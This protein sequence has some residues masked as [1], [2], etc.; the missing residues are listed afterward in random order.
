M[1]QDDK[2]VVASTDWLDELLDALSDGLVLQE[3]G[4]F[5]G[6]DAGLLIREA[7]VLQRE[8]SALASAKT[9]F[10]SYRNE[11]RAEPPS[12]VVPNTITETHSPLTI[13]S[14]TLK[15]PPEY[16]NQEALVMCCAMGE[17]GPEA[18]TWQAIGLRK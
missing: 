12:T 3:D 9:D 1:N 7:F 18:V 14:Y 11:R 13:D 5:L 16:R 10:W 4:I 2:P 17:H 8:R 15:V 6:E